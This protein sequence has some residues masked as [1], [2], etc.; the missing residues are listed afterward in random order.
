MVVFLLVVPAAFSL[1]ANA[2]EE[3]GSILGP[4]DGDNIFLRN[5]AY[6]QNATRKIT[7]Q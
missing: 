3:H 1:Y 5:F 7:L 6:S 2:S 4:E